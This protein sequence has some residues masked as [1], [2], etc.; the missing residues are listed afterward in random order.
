MPEKISLYRIKA[1]LDAPLIF[2]MIYL[3]NI[4]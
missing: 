2:S 1:E 4:V 3:E